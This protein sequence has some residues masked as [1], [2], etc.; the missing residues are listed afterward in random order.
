MASPRT[1]FQVQTFKGAVPNM[2]RG[3]GGYDNN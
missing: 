2:K 3:V 1:K